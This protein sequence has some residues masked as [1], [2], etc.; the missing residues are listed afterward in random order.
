MGKRILVTGGTG[1][2]GSHLLDS[3]VHRRDSNREDIEIFATRRYHLSRRDKVMHLENL[4]SWVD[5]DITEAISVNNLIS[6]VKPDEIYHMAAESFVSP[7]WIHPIRYMSVNYN[8]T[9]NILDAIRTYIPTCR[10]L[11]PGSGEEYGNVAQADLPISDKTRLQPVNPYAVTKIAQDLIGY[12]YQQSYGLNVIRLRTFNHEGPRRERYF[13]IASYAYQIAKMELGLQPLVLRVGEIEDK[14]NFTH[15]LDVIG[16]YQLAMEHA[17]PGKLYLVGSESDTNIDTFRGV[18]SRL[19]QI[20]TL[21]SKVEIV[22][23]KN[24]VRPTAVP[25]LIADA[26]DFSKLTKWK[27]T[28]SL[29]EILLDVLNYW[30]ERVRAFPNL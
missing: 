2:V 23:N 9:V 14:R 15:V 21:T 13:G 29:D 16:A 6:E 4:V 19:E 7:S 25:Y 28:W 11:L 22:R 17:E 12:V 24:Y 20:S 5:C 3:L 30:R 1:F 10:I 8:A 18:I 26:S 27:P